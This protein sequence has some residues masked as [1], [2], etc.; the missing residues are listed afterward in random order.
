MS[1][2]FIKPQLHESTRY[3]Q[4]DSL[5]G[6][7]AVAVFFSHFLGIFTGLN[8]SR[9][10]STPFGVMFNGPAAVKFFFVLSG[11]VLSLPIVTKERPVKLIEF[12]VKRVLRIYPAYILAIIIALV[13]KYFLFDKGNMGTYSDWIRSF[14]NWDWDRKNLIEI[15]KAFFLIGP[16]F[17]KDMIDPV[18]WSLA[19]EMRISLFL[20]FFI[21]IVA[22]NNFN[23]GFLFFFVLCICTYNTK[24]EY[25]II[26]YIGIF[27]AKNKDYFI[28]KIRK[29][30]NWA[31]VLLC[32]L[33]LVLYNSNSE[34]FAVNPEPEKHFK[35]FL[36]DIVMAAG[37]CM[38][39]I[40]SIAKVKFGA[41]LQNPVFTFLG[42]TSYSFYL[43]HFPLLLTASSLFHA[44]SILGYCGIFLST[45]VIGLIVSSLMYNYVEIPFQKFAK[46]L[47]NRFKFLRTVDLVAL[48]EK[49]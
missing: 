10:A 29:T 49:V 39:I 47:I 40:V 46:K 19:V 26:F 6:L 14:W 1:E 17:D 27:L 4:L 5:R 45:F 8:L 9:L 35:Y 44:N 42:D 20:P 13:L 30:P 23:F 11:F 2:I 24:M 37:S 43:I 38:F 16:P 34:Y 48:P 25:V 15:C 18:I 41:Y 28:S 22:K 32:F 33:A 3:K 31:V 21:L 12:Y 36:R 7:A